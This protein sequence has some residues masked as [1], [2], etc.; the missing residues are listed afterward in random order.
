M[1]GESSRT[2]SAKGKELNVNPLYEGV[3]RILD[4]QRK[5]LSLELH[6]RIAGFIPKVSGL[7]PILALAGLLA[8]AV[9]HL[10]YDA[11]FS[12][13]MALLLGVHGIIAG[14]FGHRFTRPCMGALVSNPVRVSTRAYFDLV[15][16][17]L[18]LSVPFLL[19]G[20]VGLFIGLVSDGDLSVS[21]VLFAPLGYV[22][23]LLLTYFLL[24]IYLHPSLLNVEIDPEETAG[25]DFIGYASFGNK[26]IL[27]GTVFLPAIL[28][29]SG[30]VLAGIGTEDEAILSS[31]LTCIFAG[32]LYPML[33][34]FLHLI[35]NL[36]LEVLQNI[37][38][39]RATRPHAASRGLESPQAATS[40]DDLMGELRS[41]GSEFGEAESSADDG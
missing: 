30:L 17:F 26:L 9:V 8:V 41:L 4:W 14:Y 40:G 29:V 19:L 2:Y 13:P 28:V 18:T 27:Q 32:L 16:I 39:I 15:S 20:G 34:Y 6:D 25:N 10:F 33:A 3:D 7:L 38:S 22:S 5:V 12:L 24:T 31:G 1:T 23:V 11:W 36:Q 21:M 37:L 35:L